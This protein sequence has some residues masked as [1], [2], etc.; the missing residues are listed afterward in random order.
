[1]HLF[2]P[3][4]TRRA[5]KKSAGVFHVLTIGRI[6]TKHCPLRE[7]LTRLSGQKLQQDRRADDSVDAKWVFDGNK[8]Q[9]EPDCA[10]A[11]VVRLAGSGPQALLH[12]ASSVFR[13]AFEFPELP[14]TDCFEQKA[15]SPYHDADPCQ[16]RQVLAG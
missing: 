2:G 13:F 11:E 7:R 15:D 8:E 4:L 9:A 3:T 16:E 1:M 10:I 14:V 6:L 5:W 12:D